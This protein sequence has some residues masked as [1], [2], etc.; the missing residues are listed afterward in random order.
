M[1]NLYRGP[2]QDIKEGS[3]IAVLAIEDP[4]VYPF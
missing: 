1:E 3:M 2:I 4:N